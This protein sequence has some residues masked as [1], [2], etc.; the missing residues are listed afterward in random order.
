[1][2]SVTTLDEGINYSGYC[3]LPSDIIENFNIVMFIHIKV[4]LIRLADVL[5]R[6]PRIFLFIISL[7]L[8][9]IP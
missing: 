8:L 5:G 6:A 3:D 2:C 1:M 4:I 7:N 9:K